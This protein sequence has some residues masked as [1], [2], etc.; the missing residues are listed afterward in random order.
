MPSLDPSMVQ[1][2]PVV[3]DLLFIQFNDPA[4]GKL[5]F[6]YIISG[7][8]NQP[9]RKGSFRGLLI[10]LRMNFLKAGHYTLELIHEN[11]DPLLFTFEKRNEEEVDIIA[12]H[13]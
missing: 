2:T 5:P 11:F 3:T 9:A 8:G 7:P 12:G 6:H 1:V 4:W 10:Q 13:Y